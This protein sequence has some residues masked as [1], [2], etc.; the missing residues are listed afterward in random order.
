MA[1]V[2]HWRCPRCGESGWPTLQQGSKNGQ[3][4]ATKYSQL[5]VS[6]IIVFQ[7]SGSDMEPTTSTR[8]PVAGSIQYLA[9]AL[10][11]CAALFCNTYAKGWATREE[12]DSDD[13]PVKVGTGGCLQKCSARMRDSK[14]T[15]TP[16]LV[17]SPTAYDDRPN[18]LFI[19]PFSEATIK[20]AVDDPECGAGLQHEWL[21]PDRTA[22]EFTEMS[23]TLVPTQRKGPN[24]AETQEIGREKLWQVGHYCI[25][26]LYSTKYTNTIS[27]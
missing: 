13:R 7:R 12:A 18:P 15:D 19:N 9:C 20:F 10:N 17:Q 22:I 24:A 25:I 26:A 8:W 2:S 16:S 3:C 14:F 21:S 27:M 11:G 1:L 5:S 4:N 6:V 23:V